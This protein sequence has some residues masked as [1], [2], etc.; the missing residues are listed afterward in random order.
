MNDSRPP[1]RA[2][3]AVTS[4]LLIVDIQERLAPATDDP[5]PVVRN[6]GILLRA[7]ARL[8]IPVLVSEQ[9][10]RGLGPTVPEIA[11]LVAPEAIVDKLHFSCVR[12][13]GWAERFAATGREAAVVA[14]MEAH[15]CVLQTVL[16]L[17][18]QGVACAVVAD[19]VT[20]RTPLNRDLA[21]DRMARAGALVVSTE[22]VVFEW[23]GVAGTD[24][25]R[26]LSALIR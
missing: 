6:A 1:A 20:S 22:M 25:F 2:L 21:L 7:A 3:D 26:E 11:G 13:V 5:E 9:Y 14:G 4:A 15:V 12:D 16:G 8:E 10:P 17:L 23:L 24:E 18:D 19:A